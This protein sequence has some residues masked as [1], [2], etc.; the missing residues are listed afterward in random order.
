MLEHIAPANLPRL[1][2]RCAISSLVAGAG[3]FLIVAVLFPFMG[4][5]GFAIGVVLALLNLRLLARQVAGVEH[6][7]DKPVKIV[8]RNLASKAIWRLAAVTVVVGAALWI[9]LDLCMGIV[10]GLA[11]YQMVF[12]ANVFRAIVAEG[13]VQ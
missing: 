2:R 6:D 13:G 9:S 12:I 10:A 4:A 3:G 1:L 7:P 5:L 8:R 11:V